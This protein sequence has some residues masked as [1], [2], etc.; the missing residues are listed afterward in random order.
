[1]NPF[2]VPLYDLPEDV[3]KEVRQ[4]KADTRKM[5]DLTLLENA[6]DGVIRVPK[7]NSMLHFA[8]SLCSMVFS[9]LEEQKK[10]YK[11]EMHLNK[12][13]EQ[14]AAD[15]DDDSSDEEDDGLDVTEDGCL[16]SLSLESSRITVVKR[17]VESGFNDRELAVS[18]LP[19]HLDGH[20]CVLLYRSGFFICGIYD[21]GVLQISRQE[22]RYTTRRKQGGAQ[23]KKDNGTGK[24]IS[25]GARLRR[26]NELLIQEF[27]RS[28]LRSLH[29]QIAACSAVF[30]GTTK[31]HLW[32]SGVG[33]TR[34][35]IFFDEGCLDRNDRR[36]RKIPFFF[37]KP[38]LTEMNR[39]YSQLVSVSVG[40][41]Q[42]AAVVLPVTTEN[43]V[44]E[45]PME[46]AKKEEVEVAPVAAAE[47]E[48]TG[49]DA[50]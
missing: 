29:D 38:N 24:A 2:R 14:S 41:L 32:R 20:F 47:E 27:V 13:K 12:L 15:S 48:C 9:S 10:H 25:M 37:K 3:K 7:E 31:M 17:L 21:R 1:M 44:K 40:D 28:T 46:E 35:P 6:P 49:R 22:K 23:H 18:Q 50:A 11:S 30:L 42:Q 26:H 33:V 4:L 8:C 43:V 19:D 5:Q 39:I 16:V 36:V 45:T 34:R